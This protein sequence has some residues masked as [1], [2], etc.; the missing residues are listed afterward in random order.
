M[1]VIKKYKSQLF[2]HLVLNFLVGLF[3]T[4]S[5][6][7]HL[8]LVGIKDY[9]FY[10]I[11]F[12]LLQ[13][14]VFGFLYFLSLHKLIF[15]IFFPIFFSIF[16]LLSYWVYTQDI[17]ISHS[18]FQVFFETKLDIVFGIITYHFIIFLF[19]VLFAI[20][21]ILK[22]Y[23]KVTINQLYS[24]LTLFAIL[25]IAS[26]FWVENYR[27]GT[28][29]RR[30][31]YNAVFAIRDYWKIPD[32]RFKNTFPLQVGND[33]LNIIFVLGESVRADHLQLNGYY[34]KTNPYLMQIKNLVSFPNAYTPHTYTGASVPQILTDATIFDDLKLPKYSLIDVLNKGNITTHW[35]GNQTPEKSYEVFMQQSTNQ[36]LLD[37]LHSEL[38]FQKKM[39]GDLLDQVKKLNYK[40]SKQFILIHL[41]GSHWYYENRYPQNFQEFKPV[42]RSK[43][44]PSNSNDEI[45]NS[46]DNTL[47]YL[48]YFLNNLIQFVERQNANTMI[49]YLSDHGELLGENGHWLHAQEGKAVANPAFIIW[50]SDTFKTNYPEMVQAIH[51]N[52]NVVQ[53]LDFFFPSILHL[54]NVNG[55][56]YNKEKSIFINQ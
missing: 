46:Y 34:R 9:V 48:D 7:I 35:I 29:K 14:S 18:I 6:Y 49:I 25:G 50:Y 1:E 33:S 15:R 10:F 37:P 23:K 8:P 17:T 56:E 54:Y 45:I 12:L 20:V 13:F 41:M 31:P 28:F 32:L 24:P 26:F 36:Y 53:K 30:L 40:D 3:I 47:L 19:L 11:H 39:D 16:S 43:Y 21:F 51:H 22:Y 38:N 27:F 44:I 55:I 52:K 42:A 4:F 2:F 5:T